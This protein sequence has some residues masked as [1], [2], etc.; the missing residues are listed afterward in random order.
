MIEKS[1][2]IIT[3]NIEEYAQNLE[4][5]NPD[6]YIKFFV[7]DDFLIE[8]AKSVIKEAYVAEQKMKY[9]FLGASS[10][11]IY[12]QNALLK[13]FE[14]PPHNVTFLLCA[15]SKSSLLPTIRSRL[16]INEIQKQ[17]N[18]VDFELN[19]RKL[20]AKRIF[21]FVS[22]RKGI[23]KNELKATISAVFTKA[24][25]QGVSFDESEL[26]MMDRFFILAS[27]NSKAQNLLLTQLLIIYEKVRQ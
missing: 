9:I 27:L 6:K 25:A 15:T 3:P 19:F 4:L 7:K 13:I 14:E 21:E 24:L 10:Y 16:L 20:D 2:I 26:E 1:Q 5:S 17:T 22:E 11:N 23:D 8:D 18:E 12:A